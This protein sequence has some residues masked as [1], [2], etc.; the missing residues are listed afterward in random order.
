MKR[1]ILGLCMLAPTLAVAPAEAT[2]FQIDCTQVT[3]ADVSN[4]SYSPGD[5]ILL[6]RGQVCEGTLS[7]GGSG[8]AANPI[9]I[10][11]YGTGA[12][13]IIDARGSN[14]AIYLNNQEGF[15]IRDVE[16][17]GGD[18]YGVNITGDQAGT[19]SYFRI[20]NVE[21]RDVTGTIVDGQGGIMVHPN[22]TADATVM[23]DVRVTNTVVH[24]SSQWAG[25]G[26]ICQTGIQPA[27]NP[28]PIVVDNSTAYNIGGD[29]ITAFACTDATLSDSLVH[30][31]GQ[32]GAATRGT[33]G[34]WTWACQSCSVLRNEVY[35][36]GSSTHGDGGAYDIDW[37]SH[38]TTVAYNYGHDNAGYCVAIF[39]AKGLT[40]TNSVVKHNI[41]VDNGQKADFADQGDIFLF[42]WEG[43]AIDGV[44]IYGNTIVWKP[45]IDAPAFLARGVNFKGIE[46]KFFRNNAILSHVPN[47]IN[48]RTN[49]KLNYNLYFEGDLET[50]MWKY[51]TKTYTTFSGYKSGSGQDRKG[52]FAHPLFQDETYSGPGRPTTAFI[53]QATS[54]LV[55]AG[56][57]IA[58][59]FL[60]FAGVPIPQGIA[61]D[62]GAHESGQ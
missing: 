3:L 54:P 10:G 31:A 61:P 8:T 21:V 59:D 6:P 7:P 56:V 27:N 36:Q 44:K 19:F 9:V 62:I 47:M 26:I 15:E 17:I 45:P 14:S 28:D 2:I 13:P 11:A 20:D 25:I 58:G 40:T 38:D 37:G 35:A 50:P 4:Q 18:Q 43:G 1:L 22:P 39:G 53:P 52:K 42:T 12:R 32:T 29:G 46:P 48:S 41:C 57:G 24:D 23:N 51:G 5:Q 30:H 16:T 34:I 55:N 60:D 33:N 49:V